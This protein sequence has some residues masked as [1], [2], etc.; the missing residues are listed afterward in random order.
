MRY[1]R[2][3]IFEK[4]GAQGQKLLEKSKVTVI[5]LGAIGTRTAELLAR[6]GVG[7]LILIDRDVVETSNLQRQTLFTEEDVNKS[8]AFASLDHLKKINSQIKIKAIFKDI[9]HKNI[10]SNVKGDLIVDCTDNM[11]TRFL[12]N[13]FSIE[14]NIPWIFSSIIGSSGMV[15]NIIPKKTPCFNCIFSAP[16]E[17]LGTCDTEGIINTTASLVSSMQVTEAFKILTKQPIIKELIYFDLW[18]NKIEKTKIKK[19][20]N[21]QACNREFNYLNGKNSSE[22]IKICGNNSYQLKGRKLKLK[23]V[24]R[25]LKKLD[26]VLLNEHC[27]IFKELTMFPDGR[28]LVKTSSPEKAK[29]IYTKYIGN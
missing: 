1:S 22:I 9:N 27:L 11:E 3:I 24:A 28:T 18:K 29:S 16:E 13:E 8:K 17:V 12:I 21:C 25:K 4:I 6:A 15:F 5:G 7:N 2:Q 14:K 10:E 19:L 20:Q 26:K 23:E